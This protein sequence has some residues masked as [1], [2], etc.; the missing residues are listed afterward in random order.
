MQGKSLLPLF[1]NPN[2]GEWRNS[3]YYH[4]Y[5][6]GWGVLKH[7]GIRTDRHKLIHYYGEDDFWELFDL[8]FD[9]QEMKNLYGQ[10]GYHELE[11]ELKVAL[12][13]LRQNYQVSVE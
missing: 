6:S 5:E 9:P 10:T 11:E 1:H 7:E 8:K 13:S 3:L 2:P 4:F 12:D